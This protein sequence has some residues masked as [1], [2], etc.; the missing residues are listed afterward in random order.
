MPPPPNATAASGMTPSFAAQ[1]TRGPGDYIERFTYDDAQK[2]LRT[3]RQTRENAQLYHKE[4]RELMN[5]FARADSSLKIQL[6]WP[7]K[8]NIW[9]NWKYYIAQHTDARQIIGDGIVRVTAQSIDNQRDQ[10]R[11]GAERTDFFMY[12]EDGSYAR[13]H[14]G[15]N[16]KGDAAVKYGSALD[17]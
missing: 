3:L 12:H 13:L 10:N 2:L 16:P 5:M 6:V 14:P 15:N 8:E 1:M 7:C 11:G 17:M 9:T 4:A